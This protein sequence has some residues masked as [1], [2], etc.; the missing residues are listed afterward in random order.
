[1]EIAQPS[2]EDRAEVE[3]AIQ[4]VLS[5][6]GARV[7]A[8]AQPLAEKVWAS[9]SAAKRPYRYVQA[10]GTPGKGYSIH[11]VEYDQSG[12]VTIDPKSGMMRVRGPN[13][14]IQFGPHDSER[15]D[16]LFEN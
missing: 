16:Y 4:D 3:R 15:Y 2:S 7:Q 1:M 13:R 6:E 5:G 12:T 14:L 11:A 9:F 10:T 8:A